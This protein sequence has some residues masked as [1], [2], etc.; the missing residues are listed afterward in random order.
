MLADG[1]G[2]WPSTMRSTSRRRVGRRRSWDAKNARLQTSPG[3]GRTGSRPT[4]IFAICC[5][6]SRRAFA[7]LMDCDCV[8]A[9]PAG[10]G[11]RAGSRSGHSIFPGSKGILPAKASLLAPDERAVFHG[12]SK[13][14]KP[15]HRQTNFGP[16]DYSP[17]DLSADRQRRVS[18]RKCFISPA[19]PG[20]VAT[21]HSGALAA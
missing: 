6:L 2:F 15:V 12:P 14:R 7:Q 10:C 19:E 9:L 5:E 18:N 8:G 11:E 20:V 13:T 21:R 4:W 3:S 16:A 1:L 17:E